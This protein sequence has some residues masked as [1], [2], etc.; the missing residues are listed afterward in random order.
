MTLTPL[1][2]PGAC[3]Q[4]SLVHGESLHG[5]APEAPQGYLLVEEI[6]PWGDTGALA[7]ELLP[8]A[9]RERCQRAGLRARRSP[10][11][12]CVAGC[13]GDDELWTP[14]EHRVLACQPAT[15]HRCAQEIT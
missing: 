15:D 13:C 2:R 7:S 11:R 4:I 6:R 12:I 10:R 14:D 5:I 9:L 1:R 3:V 8:A